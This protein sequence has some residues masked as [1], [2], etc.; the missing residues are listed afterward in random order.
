MNQAVKLNAYKS[1]ERPLQVL[2]KNFENYGDCIGNIIFNY[3]HRPPNVTV[4]YTEPQ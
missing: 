1:V 3:A 4:N 2:F